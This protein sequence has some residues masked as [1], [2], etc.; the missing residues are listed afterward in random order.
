MLVETREERRHWNQRH[1]DAL[2][3]GL[4][5]PPP[6]GAGKVGVGVTCF[7]GTDPDLLWWD[8]KREVRFVTTR[9][10]RSVGR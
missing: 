3:D 5:S 9:T 6:E 1:T 7:S 2:G 10:K 4:W 8:K